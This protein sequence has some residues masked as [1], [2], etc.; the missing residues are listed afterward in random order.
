M[1]DSPTPEG[2]RESGGSFHKSACF[3]HWG[4]GTWDVPGKRTRGRYSKQAPIDST[5]DGYIEGA[6]VGLG[7]DWAAL[8]DD[9]VSGGPNT[10]WGKIGMWETN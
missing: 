5:R 3:V 8:G 6:V 9:F 4:K 1:G 2:S 10:I 7:A